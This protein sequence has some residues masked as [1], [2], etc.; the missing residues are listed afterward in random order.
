MEIKN[1]LKKSKIKF[2]KSKYV[3]NFLKYL[4]V[5]T[6]FLSYHRVLSDIEFESEIRP[7]NNLVVSKSIFDK[8]IKF[9]SQNFNPTSIN[10]V[11]KKSFD[12]KNK[13]VITFD[14]GYLDNIINA[15]P[16]LKKYNCPA[17][18]YVTTGFLGNKNI[19]WWI[20]LWDLILNSSEIFYMG[21][22]INIS[23]LQEKKKTY[24]LI[25]NN[26]FLM[27]SEGINNFFDDFKTENLD[28]SS[29]EKNIFMNYEDLKKINAEKLIEIGCHT[30]SHQNLKI[31]T[32]F[33]IK[34]ELTKSKEF[35]ESLLEREIK[36]F[37]IPFGGKNS[38]SENILKI[39]YNLNFE[40]IVTTN[41][42]IF[43]KKNF[44][45]IPRIGIGN[46]DIDDYLYSKLIGF[47]SLINKLLFR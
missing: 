25:K 46:N 24:N 21:K 8:Q 37:S 38:Y 29:L 35:L 3:K 33:E 34:E 16:I 14:D 11:F 12:G 30:H 32:E 27:K 45:K 47:D 22:R 17:I 4:N 23:K 36:H 42:D 5:D 18:I 2:S 19:A 31:L 6:V 28:T 13:I 15:V 41:H 10:D 7:D 43:K 1:F 20:R 9:I 40:T 44:L 26:L 39:I